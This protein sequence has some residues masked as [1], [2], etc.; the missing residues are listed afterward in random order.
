MPQP[1]S[2]VVFHRLNLSWHQLQFRQVNQA[3]LL[4]ASRAARQVVFPAPNLVEFR[5]VSR[6]VHHPL[7]HRASRVLNP[8]R[9]PR[10]YRVVFPAVSRV[11]YRQFNLRDN[12]RDNL[13]INRRGYLV[14]SHRHNRLHSPVAYRRCSL[15]VARVDN[16]VASRAR[17]LQGL[18]VASLQ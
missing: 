11:E 13:V 15:V 5:Q 1:V 17:Y 16:L 9:F 6:R 18:Q 4:L 8:L 12:P 3:A 7:G 14:H 2:R 10:W